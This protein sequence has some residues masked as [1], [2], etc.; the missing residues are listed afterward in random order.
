MVEYRQQSPDKGTAD[1]IRP[2]LTTLTLPGSYS[3]AGSK[4]SSTSM[5]PFHILPSPTNLI[6]DCLRGTSQQSTPGL[7]YPR[8]SLSR[9]AIP[10]GKGDAVVDIPPPAQAESNPSSGHQPPSAGSNSFDY[11]YYF[12]HGTPRSRRASSEVSGLQTRSQVSLDDT[13]GDGSPSSSDSTEPFE[14][15]LDFGLFISLL[16][17]GTVVSLFIVAFMFKFVAIRGG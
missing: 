16:L 4:N 5:S 9:L 8:P 12:R 11:I 15:I 2:L 6:W 10:G 14:D 13:T 17:L 3:A 7:G 1:E